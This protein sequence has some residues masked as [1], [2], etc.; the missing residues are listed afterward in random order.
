[1]IISS[2]KLFPITV[3]ISLMTLSPVS[4]SQRGGFYFCCGGGGGGGDFYDESCIFWTS[5]SNLNLYDMIMTLL[6]HKIVC[7]TLK[8][9]WLGCVILG[10]CT[11]CSDFKSVLIWFIHIIIFMCMF[12]ITRTVRWALDLAD[13]LC[14]VTFCSDVKCHKTGAVRYS[15]GCTQL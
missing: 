3:T 10:H 9:E 13:G 14:F 7:W 1:M 6:A 8:Y 2:A 12:L 4:R 5:D 15:R 11:T